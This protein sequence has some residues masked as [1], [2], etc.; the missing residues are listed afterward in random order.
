MNYLNMS[1]LFFNLTLIRA[2]Y[3]IKI[4][5]LDY[6]II[7]LL[8][9]L[10]LMSACSSQIKSAGEKHQIAAE[11]WKALSNYTSSELP[12][13]GY[14]ITAKLGIKKIENQPELDFSQI[15]L[16]TQADQQSIDL[17]KPN[18]E[19]KYIC[20][21]VCYQF[22]EYDTIFESQG[23]TILDRYLNQEEYRLFS[24]YAEM[25]VLNDALVA[26][27]RE[28][29][30]LLPY[31]LNFLTMVQQNITSLSELTDFL[32]EYLSLESYKAFINDPQ[33]QYKSLAVASLANENQNLNNTYLA[34]EADTGWN[35]ESPTPDNNWDMSDYMP[36]LQ[37]WR[38]PK[39]RSAVYS[40]WSNV[41]G[42]P[43]HVGE[44]VC[45][46]T[47]NYF[48]LVTAI[49][50]ITVDIFV[51]GQVKNISDRIF[52]NYA[53]GILFEPNE[54]IEFFPMTENMSFSTSDVAPCAIR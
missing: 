2:Q 26:M 10:M 40:T 12:N 17:L 11:K 45:S 8:A 7:S 27:H 52:T 16:A 44:M 31:Y 30:S 33:A 14:T 36:E 41:K 51:Q 4:K 21:P 46:Y 15:R 13:L 9:V 53:P 54:N 38:I 18:F 28:N 3:L 6:S 39:V 34:K 35:K 49:S 50:D 47:E 24:F 42:I 20:I 48:G 29:P 43:L 22:T 5:V 1:H 32:N 23:R 37:T 25:F 19:D